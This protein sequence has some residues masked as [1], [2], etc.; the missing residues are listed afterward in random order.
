MARKR[1]NKVEPI[2]VDR[3]FKSE[4]LQPKCFGCK[5]DYCD[6]ELCGIWFET[7]LKKEKEDD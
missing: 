2:V 6:P 7:C 1:K 3:E 5:E 4:D